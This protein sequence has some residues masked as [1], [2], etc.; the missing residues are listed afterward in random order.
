MDILPSLLVLFLPFVINPFGD[1]SFELPKI[2]VFQLVVDVLFI[3]WI[4]KGKN[5]PL[6]EYSKVYIGGIGVLVALSL[7]QFFVLPHVQEGM[8]G[9]I[10]RLSGIYLFFHIVL[11][12]VLS[13]H[14]NTSVLYK[15]APASAFFL[16]LSSLV[17][18]NLV[19]GRSIGFLG[20]AH[21]L[22]GVCLFL[23]A[24][25]LGNSSRVFKTVGVF[26]SVLP[27][28]LSQSRSGLIGLIVIILFYFLTGILKLSLLKGVVIVG[29]VLLASLFLPYLEKGAVYENRW[30]IW[31]SSIN[32]GN[33]NPV[34]GFG[35]G[36]QDY[37]IRQGSRE[38][39]T[40]TQWQSVDSAHNIF[41]DYYVQMGVVGV[42]SLL[43]LIFGAVRGFIHQQNPVLLSALLGIMTVLL[44]NPV[45]IAVL[46]PFWFL[47]TV[48]NRI[49]FRE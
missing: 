34:L 14:A 38:V 46:A 16:L 22:A 28:I 48:G 5:I 9:T 33:K 21:S 18:V 43:V 42:L 23:C 15:Y 47:L 37:V 40:L 27:I 1:Y 17:L 35:I 11:F 45:S 30:E 32:G 7:A 44:F 2:F 3:I 13:I 31:Q 4:L 41:I 20:E 19:T 12:S 29:I 24:L 25:S 36:S 6:H 10:F 26:C 49:V 8:F 39:G